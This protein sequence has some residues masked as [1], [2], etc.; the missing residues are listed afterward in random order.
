MQAQ[1]LFRS[2]MARVVS[3]RPYH[4]GLFLVLQEVEDIVVTE[5]CLHDRRGQG[6]A[7]VSCLAG[8]NWE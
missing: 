7:C 6:G 4:G 8:L 2:K 3:E 1:V 5:L